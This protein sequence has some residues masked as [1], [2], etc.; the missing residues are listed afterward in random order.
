MLEEYDKESMEL[1]LQKIQESGTALFCEGRPEGPGEIAGRCVCE[2]S[3]YM[4]D[5]VFGSGGVL[6]ELRYDKVPCKQNRS[7]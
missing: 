2:E 3:S 7:L 6:T 1:R 5:Y 4:A